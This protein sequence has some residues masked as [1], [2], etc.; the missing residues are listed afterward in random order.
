MDNSLKFQRWATSALCVLSFVYLLQMFSPLRLTRDSVVYLQMAVSAVNGEGF[1]AHGE[2]TRYP[3]G[4]PALLTLLLKT[5]LAASWSFVGLNCIFLAL[6]LIGSFVIYRQALKLSTWVALLL[7]CL[8]LLNWVFIKHM[9]LPLSD[10]PY[11]GVSL[12]SLALLVL[13]EHSSVTHRKLIIVTTLVLIM[14]AISIRT[15]GIAIIPSLIWVTISKYNANRKCILMATE[16]TNRRSIQIILYATFASLIL[17]LAFVLMW[18]SRYFYEATSKYNLMEKVNL[19]PLVMDY[20]LNELGS[21]AVNIPRNKLPFP[22]AFAHGI[23]SASGL[24]LAGVLAYTIWLRRA[25]LQSI[26]I[27]MVSYL[28]V[29]AFWPHFD[30]RFWLPVIP[31]LAAYFGFLVCRFDRVFSKFSALRILIVLYL[32]WL[33]LTGLTALAYSTRISL[34]G[35]EFPALYGKG[36]F[37]QTYLAAFGKVHDPASVNQDA[38]NLL[39]IYEPRTK[40]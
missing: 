10:V 6:G 8:A 25:D 17:G 32:C 28:A 26:D 19:I 22:L 15:L 3:P 12:A 35:S 40:P 31:L 11:F 18:Q 5:G 37:L 30:S 38:L 23:Y 33:S 16:Y 21:I 36:D 39:K 14:I 9:S 29:L 13:V 34:A 7:C 1:L 4:Y 24:I 27:Y 20:R 2:R